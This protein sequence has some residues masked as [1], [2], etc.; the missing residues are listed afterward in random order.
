LLHGESDQV[1]GLVV[2]KYGAHFVVRAYASGIG[3]RLEQTVEALRALFPVESVS[4]ASDFRLREEEGLEIPDQ[5]LFGSVPATQTIHEGGVAF[6]VDLQAG[7]KTG[8]YF[9]QRITRR[10]VRELSPGRSV[11]DVFCYTGGFAL[12]AALGGAREAIAIDSSEPACAAVKINAELNG[13]GERVVP[14]HG[15]GFTLLRRLNAEGRKFDLIVL[16]PPP[17]VKRLRELRDGLK[18]YRDINYQAMKLLAPGGALV[19]CSCS[20]HVTWGDLIEV[21]GQAAQ[22]CGREF[23]VMERIGAGPDHPVLLNMPETE[24]LR[25]Y[26][27]DTVS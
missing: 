8:F 23:Q 15:D 5:I 3:R 19:S 14:M 13:V 24:Y 17:F 7:Q 9:D 21:L 22:G 18:A 25:C 12:N 26:R 2:D 20:H 1:P 4:A 10:Q 11:L 16:D 27:L 6:S